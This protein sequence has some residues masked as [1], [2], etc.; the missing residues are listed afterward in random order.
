MTRPNRPTTLRTVLRLSASFLCAAAIT[1]CATTGGNAAETASRGDL[2]WRIAGPYHADDPGNFAAVHAQP[3]APE[4][5]G[6]VQWQPVELSQDGTPLDFDTL[7][8]PGEFAAVYLATTVVAG[9]ETPVVFELGSDDSI[10]VWLDGEIIHDHVVGRAVVPNSEH[11]PAI[12]AAGENEILVKVAQ[13]QG[14]W[15]VSAVL[16]TPG[17]TG[18]TVVETV[19]PDGTRRPVALRAA[20][21]VPPPPPPVWATERWEADP[22]TG[23]YVGIPEGII[24]QAY[25]LAQVEALGGDAFEFALREFPGHRAGR[26]LLRAEIT[27]P[28]GA[29]S[30]QFLDGSYRVTLQ[31]GR[32][33]VE[34]VEDE[35]SSAMLERVVLDS[36]TM[37]RPAPEG[38]VVLFDGS[39]LETHWVGPGGGPTT[40]R[41]E[42]GVAE[43]APQTGSINTRQGHGDVELHLEFRS[44]YSPGNPHQFYGNSGVFLQGT[45]EV[46]VLSSFMNPG[47]HNECGG[48]YAHYPPMLNMCAPPL[49]WQTYDIY[50]RAARHDAS[51]AVAERA[52]MTVYHNGVAVHVDREM[53]H[54]DVPVAGGPLM[55]QD[56]HNQVQYRNIWMRPLGEGEW[57]P[58]PPSWPQHLV[59]TGEAGK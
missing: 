36:P 24:S 46:Q 38:A 17:A 27:I 13:G 48:I 39:D 51:G 2:A 11:A 35:M 3:F 12:L 15:G 18:G 50:F 37:G 26:E 28:P 29:D 5:G 42:D 41:V 40:W 23:E 53:P 19:L 34:M 1:A 55:L 7:F 6:A 56:H 44:P 20:R 52:R 45:Y 54:E 43:V 31:H 4:T 33:F 30:V 16:A 8:G 49:Q 58:A 21:P 57:P 14:G 9:A 59:V 32:I 47:L 10:K 22:F 25:L